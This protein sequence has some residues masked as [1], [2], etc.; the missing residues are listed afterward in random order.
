MRAFQK[1]YESIEKRHD[2]RFALLCTVVANCHRDPKVKRQPYKIEDFMP[3]ERPQTRA[4]LV[5]R[6][7]AFSGSLKPINSQPSNLSS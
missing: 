1:I 5:A 7:R 3:R 4:E 6:L 2:A